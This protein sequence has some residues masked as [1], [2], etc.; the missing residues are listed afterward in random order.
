[1]AAKP[2]IALDMDDTLAGTIRHVFAMYRRPVPKIWQFSNVMLYEKFMQDI[3]RSWEM[4]WGQIRPMEPGQAGMVRT[5]AG[6][7]TI[8]IVTIDF[9]GQKAEWLKLHGIRCHDMV[10]VRRG[11]DK[12]TLDYDVFID[13][14][15]VN[16]QAFKEA[17]KPCVLFD[18]PYNRNVDAEYRIT[19]LGQ[20]AAMIRRMT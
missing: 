17:G 6:L 20:A 14:S 13:D 19:S 10:S 3:K 5:I 4:H 15:P 8:D 16:F 2:K 1:M 11:E 9:L 18:A 7:G 12:A